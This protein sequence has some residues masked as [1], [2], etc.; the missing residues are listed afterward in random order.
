[1]GLRPIARSSG[2]S[3]IQAKA[4]LVTDGREERGSDNGADCHR[5]RHQGTGNEMQQPM[6][7]SSRRGRFDSMARLTAVRLMLVI[8]LLGLPLQGIAGIAMLGCLLPTGST[9][10]STA[11]SD[12]S[13]NDMRMMD[14]CKTFKPGVHGAAGC[15]V[16]SSCSLC[17]VPFCPCTQAEAGVLASA[18]PLPTPIGAAR[19]IFLPPIKHPPRLPSL[20]G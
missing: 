16:C 1:M 17:P 7:Y 9:S 4:R 6:S 10:M 8:F 11:D 13:S 5:P 19:S 18:D 15:R 3:R 14:R 20:L 2:S 12:T